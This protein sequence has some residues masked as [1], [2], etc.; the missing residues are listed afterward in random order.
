[1]INNNYMNSYDSDDRLNYSLASIS[2]S[3]IDTGSRTN[4]DFQNVSVNYPSTPLQQDNCEILSVPEGN[5]SQIEENNIDEN[6][7][8]NVNQRNNN[9]G[10]QVNSGRR[11]TIKKPKYTKKKMVKRLKNNLKKVLRKHINEI[12]E[13]MKSPRFKSRKLLDITPKFFKKNGRKD[14]INLFSLKVRTIFE[15]EASSKCLDSSKK[16][17][18]NLIDDLL[19]NGSEDIIKILKMT[20]LECLEKY[21]DKVISEVKGKKKQ[22]STNTDNNDDVQ[23]YET[24]FSKFIKNFKTEY[25]KKKNSYKQ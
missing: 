6:H 4:N 15:Q 13:K 3:Q 12:I 16:N 5:R 18:K 24:E 14:N 17:N 7:S 21:Q 8:G 1:M 25:L 11:N 19:S 9:Q 22:V 10:N 23:E 2:L 20:F